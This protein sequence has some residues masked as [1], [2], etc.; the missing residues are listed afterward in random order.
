MVVW[1]DGMTHQF[2]LHL[3][4]SPGFVQ[5]RTVRVAE[6]V[7]ADLTEPP[8][9][10]LAFLMNEDA[11]SIGRRAFLP[12]P[13]SRPCPA[14]RTL[15]KAAAGG[16]QMPFLDLGRM[17][18]SVR[19]RVGEDPTLFCRYSLFAPGQNDFGQAGMKRN[20]VLGVFGLDVVDPPAHKA[21][22][23]EKLILFKIEIVPLKRR[24]LAHAKTKALGD[25]N[26][27]AI[28]LTQCRHEKFELLH[29]QNDGAL[30]ALATALDTDQ[31][32][33]VSLFGEELPAC[34]ALIHK[35]HHASDMGLG[36]RSHRKIL[37]PILDRHRSNLVEQ[38]VAQRG[39][40]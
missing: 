22:L 32:D 39:L 6:R 17:V 13:E 8:R 16:A 20:I 26:H 15:H 40:R 18:G 14:G 4:R 29:S 37:K 5:P 9:S 23:N 28:R 7:P 38:I 2:L 25:L 21:T 24:D 31:G 34:G 1:I 3:H 12:T 19:H 35:V 33:R 36:L 27:R 11:L 10:Q 30:P